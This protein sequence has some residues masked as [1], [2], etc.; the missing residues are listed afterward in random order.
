MLLLTQTCQEAG[1]FGRYYL[2]NLEFENPDNS[3]LEDL[4]RGSPI[5]E[6]IY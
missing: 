6:D 4:A 2:T 3:P 1:S 5:F